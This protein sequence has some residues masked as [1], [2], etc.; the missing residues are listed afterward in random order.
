M[1]DQKGDPYIPR[2]GRT[3]GESR[4]VWDQVLYHWALFRE[5]VGLEGGLSPEGVTEH[6]KT[7]AEK[8]AEW[9]RVVEA[10]KEKRRTAGTPERI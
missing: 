2:V 10:D 8:V 6:R 7:R 5:F 1:A 9:K 4:K 3:R